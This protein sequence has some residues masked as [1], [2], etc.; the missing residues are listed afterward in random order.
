MG[1]NWNWAILFEP[2]PTGE[3]SFISL[4]FYGLGWTLATASVAWTIA[5]ILGTVLGVM[6]T[7]PSP[8]LSGSARVYVEIFRNIPVLVQLFLW[9]FVL[10]EL[11]PSSAGTWLKQ[12]PNAS[13][14]TAAIGLGLYMAA[15][16]AEQVRSGLLS[17]PVGQAMA[18]QSLG[19]T[20]YQSLRF[21]LLPRAYRVILPT[22]TTDAMNAVKN[23]S[24]ASTIGL[25]ELTAQAHAMQEFSFQVFEAFT[26][27]TV[28]YIVVNFC[29]VIFM[30]GLEKKLQMP[31]FVT[32]K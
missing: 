6:R 3:G 7:R 22:L 29:V 25:M 24:V 17:I 15:R 1:Y 18:C 23:T 13:Y 2:S 27:A 9:Y 30:R 26:A 10:P 31:G 28:I 14:Y 4:L 11:L 19:M 16:I 21:V 5:I 20:T 8:W 12:L 32:G